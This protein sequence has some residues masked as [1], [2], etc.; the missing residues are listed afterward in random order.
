VAIFRSFERSS[1]RSSMR[2]SIRGETLRS[3]MIQRSSIRSRKSVNAAT[4]A[5]NKWIFRETQ[6]WFSI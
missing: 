2:A 3:S 6:P 5:E 1:L 4:E